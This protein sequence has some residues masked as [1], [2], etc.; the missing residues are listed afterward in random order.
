MSWC[1]GAAIAVLLSLMAT[2]GVSHLPAIGLAPLVGEIIW[3][4]RRVLVR[5]AT[6]ELQVG[7]LGVRRIRLGANTVVGERLLTR[8]RSELVLKTGW[9]RVGVLVASDEIEAIKVQIKCRVNS[10]RAA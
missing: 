8:N 6:V 3:S 9:H 2:T 4:H 10:L 1:C 7:G 5:N